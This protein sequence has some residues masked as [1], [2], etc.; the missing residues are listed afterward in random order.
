MQFVTESA[1]G[2][3]F[4]CIVIGFCIKAWRRKKPYKVFGKV[5]DMPRLA[6]IGVFYSLSATLLY[7]AINLVLVSDA[8]I[9]Y[10]LYPLI[11]TMVGVMLLRVE[12]GY[13]TTFGSLI[14]VL[15]ALCVAVPWTE[16]VADIDLWKKWASEKKTG[17]GLSILAAVA[18]AIAYLLSG[19]RWDSRKP[20]KF[21]HPVTISIWTFQL[22]AC[23]GMLFLVLDWPDHFIPLGDL[24]RETWLWL[25][26]FTLSSTAGRLL[27]SWVTK[28][29]TKSFVI[30][31]EATHIIWASVGAF[32]TAGET[33]TL[34]VFMGSITT[35]MGISF[36][37]L[38]A[39]HLDDDM[40]DWNLEDDPVS[41]G[42]FQT[43]STMFTVD[44]NAWA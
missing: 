2:S 33:P 22:Q 37:S 10:Y 18:A 43:A 13:Q 21:S 12:C 32:V 4:L 29:K 30:V 34:F 24:G 44:I 28:N 9:L 31:L 23:G 14:C 17:M 36:L 20:S 42:V 40:E 7:F 16:L 19:G 41:E 25:F 8:L 27:S 1:I 6:L 15:G 26:F 3:W 39:Q 5:A 11:A 35:I 38:Q